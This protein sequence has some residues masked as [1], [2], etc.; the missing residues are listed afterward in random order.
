MKE[1]LYKGQR[2]KGEGAGPLRVWKIIDFRNQCNQSLVVLKPDE[3][4]KVWN[5]SP[6]GFQ[7]GYA[8]SGP[9]Q[10][11]LALLLDA[12]GDRHFSSRRHQAFKF[13]YVANWGDEWSMTRE[14]ILLWCEKKG[15][16][17]K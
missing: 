8:G 12:T 7:W 10:L 9:A 11:A 4:L 6:D 17:R 5:H 14:E 15:W 16:H 1:V 13:D 3:S 2:E